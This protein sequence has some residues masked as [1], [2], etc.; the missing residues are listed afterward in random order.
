LGR[1]NLSAG[2][3][4]L[5]LINMFKSKIDSSSIFDYVNVWIPARI[6][7]DYSAFMIN[8]S[9]K[10]IPSASCVSVASV[11]CKGIDIFSKIIFH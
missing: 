4:A 3:E 5:F 2:L 6:I 11:I 10:V 8:H 1:L 7:R 9:F